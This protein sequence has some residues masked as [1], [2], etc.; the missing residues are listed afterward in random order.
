MYVRAFHSNRHVFFEC[1]VCGPFQFESNLAT[2]NPHNR[3]VEVH[4]TTTSDMDLVASFRLQKFST[5]MLYLNGYHQ[6]LS[7]QQDLEHWMEFVSPGG[8]VIIDHVQCPHDQCKRVA[9]GVKA[10]LARINWDNL[11]WDVWGSL[12]NV[13][14]AYPP[15]EQL[16]CF[17][18][19]RQYPH[20]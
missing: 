1:F 6:G 17:V 10:L 19:R 15:S 13:A 3:L 11:P 7:V 20:N 12:P 14:H 4:R 18:L 9:Q 2:F 8:F 5:D 16:N